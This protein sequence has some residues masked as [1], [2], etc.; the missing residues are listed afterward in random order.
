MFD[1]GMQSYYRIGAQV[2]K[3]KADNRSRFERASAVSFFVII[4]PYIHHERYEGIKKAVGLYRQYGIL[5]LHQPSSKKKRLSVSKKTKTYS[6]Y[7]NDAHKPFSHEP[8]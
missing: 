4:K 3:R 2:K 6:D 8:I 1:F 7:S 5:F